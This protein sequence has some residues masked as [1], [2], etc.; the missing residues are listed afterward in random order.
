MSTF[1]GFQ[2][3]MTNVMQVPT[4]AVPA[5]SQ[6]Q[7]AYDL[8][9]YMVSDL[10]SQVQPTSP[11]VALASLYD[12]AVYNL[13]GHYLVVFT[14]DQPGETPANYWSSLR[15]TLGLNAFAPGIIMSASNDSS[16]ASYTVMEFAKNLTADQL[17][18]LKT[19][20]GQLYL[21]LAQSVSTVWGLS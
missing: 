3:F 11:P 15:D 5:L 16:S 6:Q 10:L 4:G 14:T 8:A 7:F 18:M 17:Q 20:W 1:A 21:S 9:C 13:A 2:S 12:T 19:P